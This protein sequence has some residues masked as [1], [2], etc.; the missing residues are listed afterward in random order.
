MNTPE[1][2]FVNTSSIQYFILLFFL[3]KNF[4]SWDEGVGEGRQIDNTVDVYTID[5]FVYN[6]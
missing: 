6:D 2:M 4:V 3:K 5:M 1:P